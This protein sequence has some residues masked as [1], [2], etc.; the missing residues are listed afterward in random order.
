MFD[1]GRVAFVGPSQF[2]LI[3][4]SA[5]VRQQRVVQWLGVSVCMCEYVI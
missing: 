3:H 5:T 1:A 4:L 2:L